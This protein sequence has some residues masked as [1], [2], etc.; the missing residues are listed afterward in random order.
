MSLG[1]DSVKAGLRKAVGVLP[2]PR[3]EAALR[4][5]R[6]LRDLASGATSPGLT[7][8]GAALGLE[9][10]EGE[11][12]TRDGLAPDGL[13]KTVPELAGGSGSRVRAVDGLP[14]ATRHA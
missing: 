1:K 8:H 2:G 11:P 14:F 3:E 13:E 4:T 12:S 10:I 9:E 5:L 7:T 6:G